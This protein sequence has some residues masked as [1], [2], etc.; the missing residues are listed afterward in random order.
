MST[1]RQT[2]L[3]SLGGVDVTEITDFSLSPSP[4]KG[5]VLRYRLT[6]G[7]RVIVRPSGT[8]PKLKLYFETCTLVNE[9]DDLEKLKRLGE[10][11]LDE[12]SDAFLALL[13]SSSST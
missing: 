8:E 1:L 5:N 2:P 4:L 11:R 6:D 9:G 3:R 7:S 10:Q 13:D 12:M